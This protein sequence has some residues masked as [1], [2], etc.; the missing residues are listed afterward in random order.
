MSEIKDFPKCPN[1]MTHPQSVWF[2]EHWLPRI[3]ALQAEVMQLREKNLALKE[4]VSDCLAYSW[5]G[6]SKFDLSDLRKRV[7]KLLE[8]PI[9]SGDVK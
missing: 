4:L 6:I 1:Y 7:K 3:I 5:E 8:E 9:G 2:E